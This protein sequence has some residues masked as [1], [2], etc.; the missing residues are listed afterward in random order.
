MLYMSADTLDLEVLKHTIKYLIL[1]PKQW[2][3]R[4][5]IFYHLQQFLALSY[6]LQLRNMYQVCAFP[7]YFW[8]CKNS[9]SF[10]Y[11]GMI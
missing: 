3:L 5:E 11:D 2:K 1:Q 10:G 8:P 6:P 9:F 7:P 4:F